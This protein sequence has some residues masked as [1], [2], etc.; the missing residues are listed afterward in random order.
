MV[1]A[2]T[3]CHSI[4]FYA[5]WTGN[6]C[7]VT[8]PVYVISLQNFWGLVWDLV[9]VFSPFCHQELASL[10]H[11]ENCPTR[12]QQTCWSDTETHLYQSTRVQVVAPQR[13][14]DKSRKPIGSLSHQAGKNLG[15]NN[16]PPLG[17]RRGAW[18]PP[19]DTWV[20]LLRWNCSLRFR[21]QGRSVYAC[22][23]V[24][25]MN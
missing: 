1:F 25:D 12:H 5:G 21:E 20:V 19:R 8:I 3:L 7:L 2:K 6:P 17:G 23:W 24:W 11:W 18:S 10:A 9:M 22:V 4:G 14:L 16:S 13:K 15:S